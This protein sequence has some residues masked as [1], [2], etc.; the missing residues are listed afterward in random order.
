[1]KYLRFSLSS[2]IT[3]T[4]IKIYI[5]GLIVFFLFDNIEASVNIYQVRQI[6]DNHFFNTLNLSMFEDS[7]TNIK[8]FQRTTKENYY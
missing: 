6:F 5:L 1:M 8:T 4:Y 7:S 3:E 2:Q